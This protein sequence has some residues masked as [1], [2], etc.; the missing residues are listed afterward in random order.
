VVGVNLAPLAPLRGRVQ[1]RQYRILFQFDLVGQLGKLR[2][3]CQPAR[4]LTTCPTSLRIE[5]Y[6]VL[7]ESACPAFVSFPLRY[8][9]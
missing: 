9:D 4:R 3:G 6:A 2:A 7:G 1:D 5:K 8:T